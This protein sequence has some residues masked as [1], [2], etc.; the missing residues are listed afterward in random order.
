MFVTER[1]ATHGE[2]VEGVNG[3]PKW[4]QR[5]LWTV[6][7]VLGAFIVVCA[8]MQ[9]P[10]VGKAMGSAQACGTCHF[11]EPQVKSKQ[12]SAHDK[13]S[14][15]DCHS[16]HGFFTKTIDEV[17]VASR[18]VYVTL[19]KAEPDVLTLSAEDREQVEANCRQC[20]AP[21]LAKL[22]GGEPAKNCTSCH[23]GTPHDRPA[24]PKN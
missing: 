21:T 19:S 1:T 13:I 8:V 14:C 6:A 3:L 22:H 20:H 17:K 2:Q 4:V 7:S 15:L 11:M 12:A 10:V 24:T 9:Y 16:S 18:H 23:R 5:L